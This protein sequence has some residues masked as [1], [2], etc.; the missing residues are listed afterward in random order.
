M[1]RRELFAIGGLMAA[2]IALPS[3]LRRLPQDFDF[4]PL[5]GF[6]GFRRVTGGAV[7]GAPNP[8]V[9]LGSRL[10]TPADPAE[11]APKA[12][13][14]PCQA[15]FGE[16]GWT[17]ERLPVAIFSDFNCPYCR[18]FEQRLMTLQAS[19]APV[20]LVWHEYPLLGDASY[21]AARAA[22][23]TRHLGAGDEAREYLWKNP[24]P[25]G[26]AG[27]KRLA[28]AL[29]IS[30]EVLLRVAAGK[31]VSE[32]LSG[33]LELGGRLGIPGTPGTVVGRTLVV[34]EMRQ[35]DLLK[36]IDLERAMPPPA[37]G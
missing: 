37:C 29:D 27:L 24:L 31:Q 28:A 3:L 15:L 13:K 21:H 22:I 17:E 16:A 34:G 12:L 25:P 18:S 10:P 1:R 32:A 5:E 23:A 2:A 20:R 36:L 7:S 19:G 6:D 11:F 33:S 35:P 4:E 9:G 26:P 14:S 30:A 8:F